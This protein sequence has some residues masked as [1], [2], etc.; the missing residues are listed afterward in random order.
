M[1]KKKTILSV[2]L[3][4]FLVVVLM[5][6]GCIKEEAEETK[7]EESNDTATKTN[8]TESTETAEKTDATAD[9]KVEWKLVSG[10][11]SD[12]CS[13]PTY[14][15]SE[16]VEISGW[17]VYDYS[18]VDKEWLLQIIAADVSKIPIEEVYG[19]EG[20]KQW[21]KKPQFLIDIAPTQAAEFKK[22]SKDD[23]E[24]VKVKGFRA[25]CEGAPQ[26]SVSGFAKI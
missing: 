2:F 10:D 17:Y 5:G 19:V 9:K 18:Y 15:A 25:Y 16:A 21:A 20:A 12:T 7:K 26:L 6:A 22:A 1:I 3:A 14:E 13:S 8:T 11:P 23:P 24:K 4:G